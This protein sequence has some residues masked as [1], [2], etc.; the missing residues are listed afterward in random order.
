[1]LSSKRAPPHRCQG[2]RQSGPSGRR[3]RV[4]RGCPPG[5]SWR[6]ARSACWGSSRPCCSSAQV[7][8]P[9]RRSTCPRAAAAG[10]RGSRARGTASAWGSAAPAS[11]RLRCSCAPAMRSCSPRRGGSPWA[12]WRARSCS[13][14]RSC[15]SDR[16]SS[17]RTSSATSR[18]RVWARCTDST[19]T[20]TSPP[21]RPP[22]GSSR[23]SAGRFSTPPTVRFSRSP[24]T[25]PR[26]WGW[27][28]ACGRSRRWRR[29]RASR[30]SR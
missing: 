9:R 14:T 5:S 30:P 6:S 28:A 19:P 24:V 27:P 29:S 21:K 25:P 23:S 4:T 10:R 3:R 20:P 15:C 2:P 8:R 13:H 17:P 1:M 22:T 16:R 18:S 7:P 26:R 12:R 11:R